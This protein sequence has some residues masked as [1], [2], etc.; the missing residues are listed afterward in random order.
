MMIKIVLND[1]RFCLKSSTREKWL[2]HHLAFRSRIKDAAKEVEIVEETESGNLIH[3]ANFDYVS[4][5][6][7]DYET[8]S[9]I[10]SLSDAH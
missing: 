6:S 5:A 1:G 3:T 8:E 10:R 4:E 7:S 9:S 2:L